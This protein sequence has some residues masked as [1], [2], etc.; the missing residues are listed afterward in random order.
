MGTV[1][2]ADGTSATPARSVRGY[3]GHKRPTWERADLAAKDYVQRRPIEAPTLQQLA[4]AYRVSVA[5]IQCR[6][7]GKGRNGNGNGHPETLTDHLLRAS[8]EERRE[9]AP[10]YPARRHAWRLHPPDIARQ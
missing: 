10:R 5:S 2:P 9:A 4:F 3:L 6:L 7:N 1:Y 8:A